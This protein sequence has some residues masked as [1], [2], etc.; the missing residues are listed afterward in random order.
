MTVRIMRSAV[1]DAPVDAVW[2][3]LRDFNGHDAWHPAIARS[4]IEANESGD[5]VGAIRAFNL[6]DGGFLREQLIAH[7]DRQM[8]FSYCLLE[9]PLPLHDYVAHLQLRPVTDGNRTLLTWESSFAPPARQAESLTQLVAGAIYEAGIAALQARFSGNA[10]P[11]PQAIS[12]DRSST[13]PSIPSPNATVVQSPAIVVSAYGG[14]E[15][16]V[17]SIVDVAPPGPGEIRLQQTAIGVNFIDLHCRAG[18]FELLSLPGVPG[19]EAAGVV[20][21]IGTGVTHLRPGDRIIYAGFPLGA[22]AARRTM[23][24]EQV[25]QLPADIDDRMAAAI[26]LKGLMAD[27][28]LTDVHPVRAGQRVLVRAA[29][30]GVG[31][32]L[33]QMATAAGAEVIGVVSEEGKASAARE[34]GCDQVIVSSQDDV[35]AAVADTT[36]GRGVDAVFDGIG[37]DTYASS[38]Q[39][40][41]ECGHLIVYGQSSGPVGLQNV[42]DLAMKSL[43]LSRP[44]LATYTASRG[45][46]EL[47]AGRLFDLVRRGRIKPLFSTQPLAQ[48]AEA[49]RLLG[50]RANLGSIVL[51]P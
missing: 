48:A 16:L 39:I 18:D 21:E 23:L 42:D 28:L 37:R 47:R 43:R 7:S 1:I 17:P 41:A 8:S 32:L 30:G 20:T 3:L 22:Y 11:L 45:E 44:N 46:I 9:A 51:I 12:L 49:H 36:G 2:H 13:A 10:A 35:V 33:C 40:L 29:A 15:V 26:F 4:E 5:L 34:A 27:A 38:L 19:V 14:P 50:Q 24:A 25:I 6:K 31:R